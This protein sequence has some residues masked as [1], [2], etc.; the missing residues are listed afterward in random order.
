MSICRC[1]YG[2]CVLALT[3]AL[4]GTGWAQTTNANLSNHAILYY[5][6]ASL[7]DQAQPK[8]NAGNISAAKSLAKESN[9]L[10]TLLQ[11]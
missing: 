2:I 1:N 7:L 10:F 8:L 9:S 6:A 3:L 4:V 5:R 11:K